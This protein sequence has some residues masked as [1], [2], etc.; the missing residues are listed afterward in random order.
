MKK[1]RSAILIGS[2]SAGAI[3]QRKNIFVGKNRWIVRIPIADPENDVGLK[4]GVAIVPDVPVESSLM[5][6]SGIDDTLEK[7]FGLIRSWRSQL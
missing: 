7:T 6:A 1:H 5:Y 4:E 2:P 3:L